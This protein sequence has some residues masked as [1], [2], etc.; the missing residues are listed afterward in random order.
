MHIKLFLLLAGISCLQSYIKISLV[1]AFLIL[2]NLWDGFYGPLD[3]STKLH[4]R[5][6]TETL[7]VSRDHG[8]AWFA[9]S[10]SFDIVLA[11]G[12]IAQE[13]TRHCFLAEVYY[14]NITFVS[15]QGY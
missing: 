2:L 14:I 3:G 8:L 15:I 10:I 11:G 7:I 9:K 1:F 4:L 12:S 13:G 6:K 5:T